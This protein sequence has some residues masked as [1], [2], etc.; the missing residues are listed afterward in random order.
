MLVFARTHAQVESALSAVR[1]ELKGLSGYGVATGPADRQ[2]LLVTVTQVSNRGTDREASNLILL[3]SR[4]E[5]QQQLKPSTQLSL[6][7]CSSP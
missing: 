1:S 2:K 6:Y 4:S 3:S 7:S 5:L